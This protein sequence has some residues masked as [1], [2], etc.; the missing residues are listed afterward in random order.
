MGTCM[1]TREVF[2]AEEKVD[3][4]PGGGEDTPILIVSEAVETIRVANRF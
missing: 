3:M 2:S 1:N 4:I